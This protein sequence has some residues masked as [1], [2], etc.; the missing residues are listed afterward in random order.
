MIIVRYAYEGGRRVGILEEDTLVGTTW[1]SNLLDLIQSGLK[2]ARGFQ[3]TPLADVQ[4][5]A[6]LVPRKIFGIGRNYADHAQELN[7][8]LPKSPLIFAKLTSSVIG[9]NEPITWSESISQQVDWEGELAVII[10]KSARNV[11][12]EEAMDYIYGYTVAN[13]VSAR[14]IQ[15]A[16][17]QWVRAKGLDTFCP[18][19]PWIVTRDEIPDPHDLT[20]TTT[21][22][23]EEVQNA[24]T[25][26][27]MFK[28]PHLISY[29]S[30][31]FTLEPGDVIL[32]GTPAG[33][34]KGMNPP[35]FLKDGDTVTV[36]ITNIGEITNPCKVE[37]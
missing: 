15:D 6:P 20:V 22:N 28:I 1:T 27:M 9:T 10:G 33:V 29:C 32:T 4:L 17:S 30:R 16:E 34:G 11:K 18:L 31:S 3:R 24:S 35:R 12:E 2:P 23:G 25:S 5:L 36:S 7:N 19:G 21:V 26:L 13:D 8:E 14:D 37:S